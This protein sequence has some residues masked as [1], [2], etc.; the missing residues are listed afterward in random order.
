MPALEERGSLS[1][2]SY[3]PLLSVSETLAQPIKY[4]VDWV[5][6]YGSSFTES[7]RSYRYEDFLDCDD[8]EGADSEACKAKERRKATSSHSTSA[9]TARVYTRPVTR[10]YSTSRA[11]FVF[12]SDIGVEKMT[13]QLMLYE[14]R[15][16]VPSELLR[17][18]VKA[19]LDE[20]W[21]RLHFGKV[22]SEVAPFLPME[23]MQVQ[24]VLKLKLQQ[25]SQGF[26]MLQWLALSVDDEVIAYLTGPQFVVYKTHSITFRMPRGRTAASGS[27]GAAGRAEA[28][29]AEDGS[30]T[31]WNQVVSI[32]AKEEKPIQR[33][34]VFATYGARA[35]KSG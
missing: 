12:I 7:K 15:V 14:D 25:L 22:I 20:Q 24:E 16:D 19:A 18:E 11:V 5:S 31:T 13:K 10:Y 17:N 33:S 8:D 9:T 32:E 30:G 29:K 2:T 4:M 21:Q 23:P 6:S 3:Q 26:R 28:S 35:V 34:K 27:A 1:S